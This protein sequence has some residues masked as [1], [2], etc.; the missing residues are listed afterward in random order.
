MPLKHLCTTQALLLKALLNHFEGFRSTF[1][2]TGKK[3]D[4][5]LKFFSLI[6]R[7]SFGVA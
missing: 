5:H 1:P 3:F 7:E 4:A 6:H 2:N